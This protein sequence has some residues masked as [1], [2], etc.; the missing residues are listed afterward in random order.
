MAGAQD[1]GGY[2]VE[3][4]GKI[5]AEHARRRR[6][7]AEQ[8]SGVTRVRPGWGRRGHLHPDGLDGLHGNAALAQMELEV[9]RERITD[10][11]ATGRAAGKDQ[12][13]RRRTFTDSPIRST[14]RLLEAGGH[15]GGT[16][17]RDVPG[18]PV[19]A[20]PGAPRACCLSEWY[21]VVSAGH[22]RA[23]LEERVGTTTDRGGVSPATGD[24]PPR[25]VVK[26]WRG[27][28]ARNPFLRWV[29]AQLLVRVAAVASSG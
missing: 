16:G 13:G 6:A 28:S 8:G 23:R 17:P 29:W 25:S 11:V 2:G 9:K 10:S 4:P 18:H 27:A 19:P 5:S 7:T 22:R 24:A 12:G 1:S 21:R 20:D 3:L 15:P 26:W 14:L